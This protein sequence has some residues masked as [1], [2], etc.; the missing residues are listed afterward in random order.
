MVETV[1]KLRVI[2]NYKGEGVSEASI[3]IEM[4]Q[5]LQ[6][7]EVLLGGGGQKTP[8]AKGMDIFGNSTVSYLVVT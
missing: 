2:G 3:C 8:C 7:P 6:F 5:N 1:C 4:N